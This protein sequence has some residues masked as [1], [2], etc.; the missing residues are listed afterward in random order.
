MALFL[1]SLTLFLVS[2]LKPNAAIEAKRGRRIFQSQATDDTS[3][4][5]SNSLMRR[6]WLNFN[7]F[8]LEES[9]QPNIEQGNLVSSDGGTEVGYLREIFVPNHP[10]ASLSS[11]APSTNQTSNE[12]SRESA[13]EISD[14]TEV[15]PT[16]PQSLSMQ[17]SSTALENRSPPQ[18]IEVTPMENSIVPILVDPTPIE[19][20]IAPTVAEP[21]LVETL[22][23]PTVA[24]PAPVDTPIIV[25]S[26][27]KGGSGKSGSS[28]EKTED[29][30]EEASEK[31]MK[32]VERAEETVA[33]SQSH[34]FA[35]EASVL[36]LMGK[37]EAAT[38]AAVAAASDPPPPL[39][40]ETLSNTPALVDLNPTLSSPEISE[41]DPS[42]PV[43]V[44]AAPGIGVNALLAANSPIANLA[45]VPALAPAPSPPPPI[46]PLSPVG[47]AEPNTADH[48]VIDKRVVE[49]VVSDDE[50]NLSTTIAHEPD[51]Q[52][53][54]HQ[55]SQKNE[56]L[57]RLHPEH[58]PHSNLVSVDVSA[59]MI[60]PSSPGR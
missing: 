25:T 9:S 30:A 15:P 16:T 50:T 47:T 12:R 46:A 36:Q 11:S 49:R 37:L 6:K 13:G 53:L 54:R 26:K 55:E 17:P 33:S 51:H 8:L 7:R 34:G 4:P 38:A 29:D 1:L 52:F 19:T 32:A 22:I 31:S 5:L 42:P 23:A 21:A 39:P 27:G 41:A 18:P 58:S 43:G 24:E 14:E 20:L 44:T 48:T 2:R 45:A 59:L 57:S 3:T 10:A 40:V 28:T 56:S 35:L 60:P